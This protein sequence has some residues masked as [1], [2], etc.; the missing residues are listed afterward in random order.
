LLG[1][2]LL[3]KKWQL[4][5]IVTWEGGF[6]MEV[7][8]EHLVEIFFGLVSAG[9]LAFCKSLWNKN[10]KLEEMQQAD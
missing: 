7:I 1:R 10:K 4:L 6:F 5:K 2:E 3:I 9:T 8:A